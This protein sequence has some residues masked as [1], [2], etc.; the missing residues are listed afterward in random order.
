MAVLDNWIEDIIATGYVA[1]DTET[2]GLDAVSCRLVGIS[3]ATRPGDACYIPLAHGIGEG[4][5]LADDVPSQLAE[6]DVLARLKP[7]LQDASIMKIL[8]NAKFDLQV[9][10]QR[11]IEVHPVEDTMLMS[12]ALA[13]GQ[14][15]H[16]MD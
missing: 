10:G 6:A 1:I 12:Y 16:G 8:Q 4:L 14:R 11:K 2:D 7:L 15:G 13:A 9:L 5:A 3:L